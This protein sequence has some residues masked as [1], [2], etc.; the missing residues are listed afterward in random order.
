M[1]TTDAVQAG[2][3]L[4]F[5]SLVL[6]ILR[7]LR[8]VLK[9]L[10]EIIAGVREEIFEMRITFAALLERERVR[11]I[12]RKRESSGPQSIPVAIDPE[13]ETTDIVCLID[14]QRKLANKGKAGV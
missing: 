4:A 7:E 13:D 6:Y 10:S 12:R 8:P 14:K 1:T 11:D 5:A 3:V 2:G 9:G